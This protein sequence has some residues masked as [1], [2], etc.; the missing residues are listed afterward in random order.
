MEPIRILIADDH[1]VVRRGLVLV[2]GQEPDFQVVG[3]AQDGEE[4]VRLAARL[5]PDLALLDWKMPK[6]DGL[7]AAWHIRQGGPTVRNLLLSGAPIKSAAL[8]ALERGVDGF[9]VKDISPADLAHAIHVVAKG[10]SYLSP[11]VKDALI[12]KS[13]QA[14]APYQHLVELTAREQQVLELMATSATYRE[15]GIQLHITQETVRTHTRRILSK[16]NQPNRTQ[17][18]IAGLRLGLIT[19]D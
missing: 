13:K 5:L 15:I 1:A 18:V 3:E 7:E 6:M 2:L 10:K 17:A 19:L 4:A 14:S 12:K 8:D 11:E 16:L 9:V